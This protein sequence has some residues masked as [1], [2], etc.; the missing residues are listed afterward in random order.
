MIAAKHYIK[1]PVSPPEVFA[2][3]YPDMPAGA[4][5]FD[6][7]K[8]DIINF[9]NG[10]LAGPAHQLI[11]A[12]NGPN[13]KYIS[14]GYWVVKYKSDNKIEFYTPAEFSEAFKEVVEW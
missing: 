2:I 13:T 3:F 1:Q 5:G 7:I 4:P 11:A 9:V 14:P 10:R 12:G 8:T 6:E